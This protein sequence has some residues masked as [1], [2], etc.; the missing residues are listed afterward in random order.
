MTPHT[1]GAAID[2]DPTLVPGIYEH[3]DQWC[4]YCPMTARC[5]AHR[6]LRARQAQNGPDAFSSLE[7]VIEFTREVS[8]AEG[9]PTP[10]LDALLSPDPAVQA[11]LPEIDDPLDDLASRYE[12]ETMRFLER[13][14]WTPPVRPT[15]QPSSIDVV[16]WYHV[17][18]QSRLARALARSM[19]AAR[20]RAD[21]L[22]DANGCAKMVLIGID[23][24]RAALGRL[25]GLCDD[26]RVASL[27]DTLDRLGPA[28]EQRFPAARAFIR[29]G[30]DGPIV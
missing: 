25:R 13:R 14:H 6:R 19:E 24:S 2:P 28:V 21:R 4:S 18:I 1:A 10:E 20:G 30:L 12:F 29:P 17:L 16:A 15:P 7:D 26:Q 27:L 9:R 8:R 11:S 3:C 23:R 22:V 5:L